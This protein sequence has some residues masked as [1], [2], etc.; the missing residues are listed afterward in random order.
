[1]HKEAMIKIISEH[2]IYTSERT[3]HQSIILSA[4][5]LST[6]IDSEVRLWGINNK[7][8][9]T[10]ILDN[11]I[12]AH[13]IPVNFRQRLWWV[14]GLLLG[15]ILLPRSWIR[16]ADRRSLL[17]WCLSVSNELLIQA[18]RL[19]ADGAVVEE[20][21]WG[22]GFSNWRSQISLWSC[23][24]K[25]YSFG[26]IDVGSK[27]FTAFY[28]SLHFC[29]TCTINWLLIWVESDFTEGFWSGDLTWL[30]DI[31]AACLVF[32]CLDIIIGFPHKDDAVQDFESEETGKV[33][34]SIQCKVLLAKKAWIRPY[35]QKAIA[36]T[37]YVMYPLNR[38][39]WETTLIRRAARGRGMKPMRRD[40]TST[41]SE[42]AC[43]QRQSSWIIM[44]KA[45]SLSSFGA[46]GTWEKTK[47]LLTVNPDLN[48]NTCTSE[49]VLAQV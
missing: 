3:V 46:N 27:A 10:F 39:D 14:F 25:K 21:F 43:E 1:M 47:L 6:L 33:E 7:T 28:S 12:T 38:T 31:I 19:Q 44:Q 49:R 23:V 30:G 48:L 8:N 45:P 41:R 18:H 17:T 9:V 29:I 24:L 20:H 26:G 15:R 5:G 11:S 16:S 2:M 4:K 13:G 34:E 42:K 37:A 35:Q 32:V 22:E 40:T 36:M